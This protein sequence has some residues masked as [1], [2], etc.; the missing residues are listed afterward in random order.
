L[1]LGREEIPGDDAVESLARSPHLVQLHELE[2]GLSDEGARVLAASPHFTNLWALRVNAGVPDA[3]R[4]LL[5]KRF[6]S[7]LC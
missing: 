7:R 6:G 3:G 4:E 1:R 2:L 5:R